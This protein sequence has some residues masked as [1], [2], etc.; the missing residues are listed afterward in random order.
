MA[1]VTYT[2]KK[3]DTLSAIAAKYNTTVTKIANLNNIKNVNLIYVGQKLTISGSTS[4]SSSTAKTSTTTSTN[5][6][7][8][9]HFGE[10]SDA[11]RTMFVTWTWTKSNTDHYKVIWYYDTGDS[12]WFIG[13][14]ST[15][16]NKQSTYSAPSNAKRVKVKIKPISKTK[17]VNNK[18]TNYWTA[19]WST[20]KIYKFD[21][22]PLKDP[23]GAPTVEIENLKLTVSVTGAESLNAQKIQFQIIQD[24]STTVYKTSTVSIYTGT[25]SYSMNV[26]AGHE[27]KARYRAV[28]GNDYSEWSS[29]SDN[30]GTQPSAVDS[31]TELKGVSQTEV[32]IEWKAVTNAKQY[33]I[34]YTTAIKYF[35]SNSSEVTSVTVD[36]TKVNH[37]EITG[38]ESGEEYFFRVRA[39]NDDGES[40]WCDVKSIILGKA[41]IA[42]TTW[43]STTTAVTGE[44]V[45][46]YWVHNSEDGSSQTWAELELTINGVTTT[47]TIENSTDEDEKDKTSYYTLDTSSYTSGSTIE[48][49]V[50]TA[51][52]TK[53]YGDWSIMRTV[54][55]YASPTLSLHVTDMD[56]N[57]ID[58][59]TEFPVYIKAVP[60]PNTQTPIGYTVTISPTQSYSTTDDVGNFK[61]VNAGDLVYSK[62]Y[63]ISTDL[64]LELLPHSV[65]LE[66]NITYTVY[67]IVS[68]NSG[69][70]KEA[71]STFTVQWEDAEYDVDAEIAIDPDTLSAYVRPYCEYYPPVYYKVTQNGDLYERTSEVLDELEGMSVED[72][73]T[74]TGDMVFSGTTND[75]ATILFCM[76]T[77]EN[78][79]LKEGITLS[80]YRRE[81]D[82]T[83]TKIAEGIDHTLNTFVVDPHPALDYARY[84]VVAITDSTGAVSYADIPG[85]PV[86][87]SSVVLQWDEIWSNFDVTEEAE[88]EAP[89]WSGS[90]VKLPYNIDISDTNKVDV[91]L[92]SYAGRSN[93]VSYYGTQI[94]HTA[95][96]NMEIPKSDKDTLYALRRLGRWLGDVYVREP[97]GSGYWA[98]ISLSY[99]Q[100]HCELTI[101]ITL[102]VTR[103]E[104]G[105]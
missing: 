89:P 40:D 98:S 105:M 18:E 58:N 74:E 51:G 81:F 71:E 101:P 102:N 17:T 85:Y 95:V 68:M 45:T 12:V 8:I 82:G 28:D 4:S 24:N 11:E 27:Y 38:M 64:L 79:T 33:E 22:T 21:M 78:G 31:I 69:L 54:S 13:N 14:E 92:V 56:G 10:Q 73:F 67:C 36:A 43:S 93:Q 7:T 80:V 103:V 59:I 94:G 15:T 65:D 23:S 5:K 61:M 63:D 100:K 97:S 49:R 9:S 29:Y 60:G 3:G 91:E 39:I 66:N 2:V 48:W 35:D 90:M 50:R 26:S 32:Y 57:D 84:R 70:T 76:C 77:P 19:E 1:T 42:P 62:H 87:E 30:V 53:E 6:V 55:V 46:L 16:E 88:L 25:A 34:E 86:G 44:N 72:A 20:E 96:W 83:F 52:I 37:A 104:G 99:S 47:K 41:P 75:G